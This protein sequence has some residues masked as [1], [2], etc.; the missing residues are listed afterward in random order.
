V[1]RLDSFGEENKQ[2]RNTGILPFD[3]A[4]GRLFGGFA[5]IAQDDD[6]GELFANDY[7]ES[8]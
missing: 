1:V 5:A 6:G 7:A 4:Q 3:F 2:K 8:S